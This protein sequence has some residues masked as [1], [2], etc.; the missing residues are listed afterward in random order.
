MPNTFYWYDLET[1]GIEPRWDRIVQ[2]AGL[3]TDRDLNEVG[4]EFCTYV[5]LPDDVLPDAGAAL[6]TGITPQLGAAEGYNGMA[7]SAPCR[8][9]VLRA[10]YLC[11]RLQQPEVR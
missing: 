3:R 4:D 6:V 1:S 9:T 5:N 8:R 10:E 2:F 11:G 7:G